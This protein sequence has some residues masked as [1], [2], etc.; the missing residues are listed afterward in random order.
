MTPELITFKQAAAL[1]HIHYE[2]LRRQRAMGYLGE[3]KVF[4]SGP[5]AR[6]RVIKQSVLDFIKA[7]TERM[8]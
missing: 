2:T 5:K 8:E 4:K 7:K 6:E 3:I 1:L